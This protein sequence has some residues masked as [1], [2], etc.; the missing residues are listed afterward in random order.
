MQ[1]TVYQR[2]PLI[3]IAPSR[4]GERP[5][6]NQRYLNS[7]WN[8]GGLGVMLSYTEDPAKLA[9]YAA[10]LDG[11]LFSGGVDVDPVRYGEEKKF[12]SVYIDASRDAF[13]AGL[14]AAVYPTNKPILG[15]CR[16]IQAINVFLGGT[17]HQ[18]I[19]GHMQE[20]NGENRPQ[21]VTVTEGTLFHTICGG[22]TEVM[23]NSFHHQ[24]LKD[25]APGLVVNA[26]SADGY[27][28]AVH[29]P[30]H[31]FLLGVQFHPEIYNQMPDDDHSR[32]LFA[33]FIAA[34]RKD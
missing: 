4:E 27:I 1:T 24:A 5:I 15:I 30:A 32:A 14:F 8:A 10:I 18:H 7:V 33:A 34:C 28:E 13:E 26:M 16:G 29:A 6:I 22:R 25:V 21:P 19:D 20:G 12:D 11:F 31:P 9:E 17:L 2:R 23:T 3:G